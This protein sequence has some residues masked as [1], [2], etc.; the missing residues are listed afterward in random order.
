MIISKR[1]FSWVLRFSSAYK[2]RLLFYLLLEVLALSFSLAFIWFS[3]QS[4]DSA[5][6]GLGRNI[7]ALLVI[8]A[9]S[10]VL[11]YT[12]TQVANY[13]NEFNKAR[14]LVDLQ[15]KILARQVLIRWDGEKKH[16]GDLMVRLIS[17]TQEIVTA[18]G[19]TFISCVVGLIKIFAA[20]WFLWWMDPWLAIVL[21]SITPFLL[22]SKFYFR[23]LRILQ[24]SLKQA[25]SE[26]GKTIQDN[27]RLRLLIRSMNQERWRWKNVETDQNDIF[28]IKKSLIGFS[29]FSKGIWGFV[30]CLSYIVA[31]VW[32]IHNLNAGLI[33]VGT[34]S[35]FLQLVIR[36]QSPAAAL[37]GNIPSLIRLGSSVDRIEE[38]LSEPVEQIV[39]PCILNEI[40]GLKLSNL[41][42]NHDGVPLVQNIDFSFKIGSPSVIL[43]FSGL[44][45]STILRTMLGLRNP[46][47]GTI[48]LT[49]AGRK[50]N[51]SPAY[52][53]NFA[54]VPQGEKI[55]SDTIRNN[56]TFGIQD[57]SDEQL[58]Q[59]L[60]IACATFVFE[61]PSG[62]ETMV[63]ESGFGLS[64]GQLQR[65]A[66]ARA[67][68]QPAS[69]WLFDEVTSALDRETAHKLVKNLIEF[70]RDRIIVFVTHD[71][72]LKTYFENTL[73]LTE[74]STFFKN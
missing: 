6:S 70:G 51:M 48:E 31:F 65:I 2:Y 46:E 20:T 26:L 36:I 14:M 60:K 18:V 41:T 58:Y 64:E 23:K 27:L 16:T 37:L 59:A 34:M 63:G 5:V 32:G 57:C 53:C 25:E 35:A 67:I 74:H 54:F 33:T 69:I 13:V 52:R 66:V 9:S 12:C 11:S 71:M 68:M 50:L 45:K 17:D 8:T 15:Q 42:L 7:T 1:Q 39:E 72:T 49:T 47:A 22:F 73:D 10:L 29:T 56:L 43:G 44:G 28:Q 4:I 21:L 30:F 62:L 19:Q 61:L 38:L 40:D 24:K 55:F 3:K